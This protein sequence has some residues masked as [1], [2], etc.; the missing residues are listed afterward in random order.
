MKNKRSTIGVIIFLFF[1]V[2]IFFV[3]EIWILTG[4]LLMQFGWVIYRKKFS[5]IKYFLT[6]SPFALM[7]FGFNVIFGELSAAAVVLLRLLLLCNAS[8]L[9]SMTFSPLEMAQGVYGLLFWL[10]WFGVDMKKVFLLLALVMSLIPLLTQEIKEIKMVLKSRNRKFKLLKFIAR[11]GE[12]VV[13]FFNSIFSKVDD[14]E[15]TLLS[16]GY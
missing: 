8:F 1:G 4:I 11:P 13:P 14:L 16:R 7:T 6:I 10:A 5:Y 15:I 2:G 9:I 12:Y 3:N